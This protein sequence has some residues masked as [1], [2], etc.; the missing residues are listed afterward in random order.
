MTPMFN[1]PFNAGT[2]ELDYGDEAIALADQVRMGNVE[3]R[4]R[5]I[6]GY[7]ALVMHKV[8]SW[9]SVFPTL[10]Y[11]RDDMVSEGFCAVTKAIN[12]IAEGDLPETNNPTGY[13]SVAIHNGISNFAMDEAIIRVPRS[14]EPDQR[15]SVSARVF[16]GLDSDMAATMDHEELVDLKDMLD[17]LCQTEYDRAIMD[18]RT[19]GYTDA[20]VASEL[21]LPPTTVY[22]LRREL[23][24]RFQERTQ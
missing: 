19:R 11:L 23:Y 10:T 14:V 1:H 20:E 2:P 13:V 21:G 6:L 24:E 12:K 16:A 7:T 3:A 4:E 8:D 18:L 22:M 17:S 9:L 5:M 15:A